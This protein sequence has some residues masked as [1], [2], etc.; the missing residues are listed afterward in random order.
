MNR[1]AEENALVFP[2]RNHDRHHIV[3][4]FRLGPAA[5]VQTLE[6]IRPRARKSDNMIGQYIILFQIVKTYPGPCCAH[7]VK[8]DIVKTGKN[9][10][11]V[12]D[13]AVSIAPPTSVDAL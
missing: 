7:G 12:V 2:G 3:R 5:K 1:S 6:K 8:N 9:D 13:I 11:T 10:T 4:V